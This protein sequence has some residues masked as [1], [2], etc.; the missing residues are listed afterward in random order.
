MYENLKYKVIKH[1][2][3][4]KSIHSF[5]QLLL[6]IV[7]TFS[8]FISNNID[9]FRE[10]ITNYTTHFNDTTSDTHTFRELLPNKSKHIFRVH[11]KH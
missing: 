1:L 5:R 2:T 9:N 8:D 4:E 6:L 10:L 7:N 3:V 11:I